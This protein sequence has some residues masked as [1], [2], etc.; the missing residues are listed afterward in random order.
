MRT[1]GI[2]T[3]R[4]SVPEV[5]RTSGVDSGR[6]SLSIII[7]VGPGEEAW[8]G[9]L[10]DL[11]GQAPEGYEV[12]LAA[13]E[14]VPVGFDPASDGRLRVRWVTVRPG[15]A[16]QMNDA[17]REA[18]GECLWFVHA[19]TRLPA[20]AVAALSE[21]IA[22]HP[23]ALDYFGLRFADGPRLLRLNEIGVA[24]RSGLFGLPFG[25]QGFCIRRDLFFR[26]G[27]FD[28]A[29]AYGED[30]LFV[31]T[32]KRNRVPLVQV[33]LAL[34]T[35]GRKYARSGWAATT[36][37]H[38]WLTVRQAVPQALRLVTGERP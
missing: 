33:P 1:V 6:P 27:C 17:A 11:A 18:R 3:A 37:R 28:E 38:V 31:W 35:S 14:P 13:V 16:M 8:A 34:R 15:R 26:L 25:D 20:T 5:I 30:H 4:S 9:L 21:R 19:D 12:L 29:A 32:A 24:L 10:S 22:A 2:G 23:T 7:P 36:C